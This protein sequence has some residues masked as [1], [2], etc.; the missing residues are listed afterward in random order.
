MTSLILQRTIFSRPLQPTKVCAS[1]ARS[2][3]RGSFTSGWPLYRRLASDD[4][5]SCVH[6]R[7]LFHACCCL[8]CVIMT[9]L[10]YWYH[11][12]TLLFT[13]Q[14]EKLSHLHLTATPV[15]G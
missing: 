9:S 10:R 6:S 2:V 13:Q 5:P 4:T 12:K 7:T 14:N 15:S 8:T 1:I 3:K 11:V